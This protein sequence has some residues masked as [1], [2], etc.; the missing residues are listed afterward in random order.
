MR[1]A[2]PGPAAPHTLTGLWGLLVAL[3]LVVVWSS[4]KRGGLRC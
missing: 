3:V 1:P 4:Q 2:G